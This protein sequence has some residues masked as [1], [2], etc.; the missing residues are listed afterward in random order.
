VALLVA[1]AGS[2]AAFTA[3]TG[4]EPQVA[5]SGDDG[6]VA[7]WPESTYEDALEV[8][9]SVDAGVQENQWRASPYE[10][11]YRF[12]SRVLGLPTDRNMAAPEPLGDGSST[13]VVRTRSASCIT[14]ATE[15]D[16]LSRELR[17][18]LRQLD[19]APNGIW[20]V[21]SVQTP[22][23]PDIS[24]VRSELVAG[25]PV[26][27]PTE[28]A[29]DRDVYVA[30]VGLGACAGWEH[31]VVTSAG[32]LSVRAPTPPE[33]A[34]EGCPI[35]LIAMLNDP[36]MQQLTGLGRQLLDYGNRTELTEVLAVPVFLAPASAEN[37][38]PDVANVTCEGATI[39]VD[40]SVVAAQ[41]DGIHIGVTTIGDTPV[42]FHVAEDAGLDS[43]VSSQGRGTSDP[44]GEIVL[45]S[46]PGRY[47]LSCTA[48][49]EGGVGI[50]SLDVVDPNGSFVPAEPECSGGE[51]WGMSPAYA[52][53]AVGDRGDPA[54]IA[55]MRLTGLEDGD[56]VERSG[57]PLGGGTAIV[58]VVRDGNVIAKADLF[59]D[60]RGGWLLSSLEGCGDSP[61]GWSSD[62]S[63]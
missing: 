5:G 38:V 24:A 25:D 60:G 2:V 47:V 63:G 32:D 6:F 19:D 20:N 15:A 56:D 61:L 37:P 54:E 22:G 7:I 29:A 21:V 48:P 33:S 12:V 30:F 4:S 55:R 45:T 18:V 40:T 28:I 9:A 43:A 44:T 53:G 46:A 62:G 35:V 41:P 1:I 8:Q 59:D 11:A 13:I 58:R 50:A 3:F 14:P 27:I 31:D 10:T 36:G 57:Y 42:A 34:P 16:C 17:L 23:F 51:G 26:D 52:P 49:T 39:T